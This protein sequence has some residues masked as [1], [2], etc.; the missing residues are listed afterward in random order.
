MNS[1]LT[2]HVLNPCLRHENPAT[3]HL[4]SGAAILH[5]R[6]GVVSCWCHV[7]QW[8]RQSSLASRLPGWMHRTG[9]RKH[10]SFKVEHLFCLKRVVVGS[11]VKYWAIRVFVLYTCKRAFLCLSDSTIECLTQWLCW[12]VSFNGVLAYCSAT[13]KCAP[14]TRFRSVTRIAVLIPPPLH[15]SFLKINVSW[16]IIRIVFYDCTRL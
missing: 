9:L 16:N 8:R 1:A 15:L 4:N 13:Q 11:V 6:K 10:C 5:I 14:H 2:A 7:P 3:N 12:H